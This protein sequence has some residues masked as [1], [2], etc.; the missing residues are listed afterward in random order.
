VL[1]DG[2]AGVAL[3]GAL[4][5][6]APDVVVPP[7]SD[8]SVA[9][10]PTHRE[11]VRLRLHELAT[12]LHRRDRRRKRHR[13]PVRLG[14][15]QIRDTMAGFAGP[16][17]TTPLPRS[18]GAGRRM[19]VVRRPVEELEHT[20]HALA[21]TVNDVL[22]AG[23]AG[24]LH[25]YLAARGPVP[26]D[27]VLRAMVP[28][29]TGRAGRQVSSLLVVGLPVGEP[30]AVRRLSAVHAGTTAAK[31]RLRATGGDAT[32]FPLPLVVGRWVVRTSRRY[33]S[34]RMTLAVTDVPGPRTPLWLA[35]ARLRTAV[36]IAPMSPLVPL[37]VAALSYAGELAVSINADAT[38]T[39]LD[40][41]ARGAGRAFTEL[42]ERARAGAASPSSS[43]PA[44]R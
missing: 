10:L 26:P 19:A 8:R 36:P 11:L 30:D 42:A 3:A 38:A 13:A 25:A 43:E 31:A 29:A 20:G 17:P 22:L 24:G 34:R 32:D 12:A 9:A 21:A 40:E 14:L 18:I 1:A 23:V 7:P 41:L 28:V 2:L 4:L 44:G 5:D 35:G 15:R 27:L 39:G 6:P 16:E 33:A 37:S